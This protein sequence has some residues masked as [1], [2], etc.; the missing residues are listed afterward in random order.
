MSLILPAFLVEHNKTKN[1]FI[2]FDCQ[3]WVTMIDSK[4]DKLFEE[5]MQ[6]GREESRLSILFRNLIAEKVGSNITDQECMDFLMEMGKATPGDLARITGLTTGAITSVIDRL[7][8]AGFVKRERD[9]KDRRKV[10]VKPI[11]GSAEK[12]EKVYSSFVEDMLQYMDKYSDSE[13]E[14]IRDHYQNMAKIFARQI[15]KLNQEK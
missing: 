5:I 2:T 13:L 1:T 6:A 9:T 11:A 12:A 14:L 4:R 15:E 10:F 7:E 8:R 3:S